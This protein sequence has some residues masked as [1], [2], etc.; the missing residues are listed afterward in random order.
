MKARISEIFNSIQGEGIYQGSQQIFVRFW[1]CNLECSYCDTKPI[2]YTDMTVDQVL[3]RVSSLTRKIKTIS[4][5]GGEPLLQAEFLRSLCRRCKSIGLRIYLETNGTLA[6][7]L[8]KVIDDVDIVALD[9]KLSSST[10]LRDWWREHSRFL[11]LAS[12]KKSFV[13]M[14]ITPSTVP[15]D[16]L[17]GV[18]IIREVN[19]DIFLVLQP[20]SSFE[21]CLWPKLTELKALAL[22]CIPNVRIVP[23]LHKYLGVR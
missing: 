18:R 11:E 19:P 13:K 4:L 7:E 5:T 12:R 14:I 2:T 22:E 16:L 1:G 8:L 10:G 6:G 15:E 23:Q 3:G 17:C 21:D 20:Q 9:F